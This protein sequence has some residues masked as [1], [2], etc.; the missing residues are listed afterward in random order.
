MA[1]YIP[2]T[3]TKVIVDVSP[4]GLGAISSQKKKTG[5]FRPAV[6]A[7]KALN[8]TERR[9]SKTERESLAVLWALQ[10]FHYFIYDREF[11]VITGRQPLTKLLSNRG[12]PT[13]RIQ[14]W[15]L[16]F[17]PYN[18]I[19]KYEPGYMNASD[20]LSKNSLPNDTNT[21]SKDI[22]HFIN[23]IISN[24]LPLSVSLDEIKCETLSD[25]DLCSIIQSV[26]TNFWDK[27]ILPPF[28]R[29]RNASL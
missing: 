6:Y 16:Q 14:R 9:Y 11:I 24:A 27:E 10:K 17:Q 5:E 2:N 20:V 7:S 12:N 29:V 18:Y 1:Y 28:C 21:V 13:P 25:P 3:E 23:N 19:I 22:E 4:I 26:N 8:P 15:L